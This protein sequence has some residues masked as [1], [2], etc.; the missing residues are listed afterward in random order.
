M[1]IWKIET[2]KDNIEFGNR[3]D[4]CY[5]CAREKAA[6]EIIGPTEAANKLKGLLE[7]KKLLKLTVSGTALVI[8]MDHIHKLSADNKEGNGDGAE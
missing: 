4:V 7:G 3:S 6:K 5:L 8:C 2:G 1:G